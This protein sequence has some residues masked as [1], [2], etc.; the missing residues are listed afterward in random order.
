[1]KRAGFTLIE[2][3]VAMIVTGI[4]TGMVF[5][6][7]AGEQG[8]YTR[9]REK[10][11]MQ[12]DAR[13]AM[14]IIEE[15]VRNAGYA[16]MM[17]ATSRIETTPSRCAEVVFPSSGGSILPGN[18]STSL[19]TGDTIVFRFY[20]IPPSGSLAACGTG[21]SSRFREI[22]Y[23]LDNGT[24]KRRYR[25]DTT[26]AAD[27]IPFLENVVSFQVRYG[28]V[29]DVGNLVFD[30]T[31]LRTAS[32][33]DPV[34][35]SA[36]MLA[37]GGSSSTLA[38]SG[39]GLSSRYAYFGPIDTSRANESYR[40]SMYLSANDSLLD[41]TWGYDS[42]SLSIGLVKSNLASYVGICNF[43]LGQ[44]AGVA[45]PYEFYFT[46]GSANIGNVYLAL[47]G[48]LRISA[49]AGAQTLTVS[50]L[51]VER[52]SRGSYFTW[53]DSPSKAEMAKVAAVRINLVVKTPLK[54]GEGSPQGFSTDQLGDLSLP[55]GYTAS[56]ADAMKSH[57]LYQRIIPVVNNRL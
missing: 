52:I 53:I 20:E 46:A 5:R 26:T 44:V 22:G 10:V 41:A 12:A 18:N 57:I 34:A 28:L 4:V 31:R 50:R 40:L 38:F 24:L 43:K 30:T 36:G 25:T 48:R 6:M 9:T 21:S 8:N 1:V 23:R 47:S 15:E 45:V 11:K 3:L 56:G 16:T 55:S 54:S 2:L 32:Y 27:W 19:A 49:T 35:N 29:E 17:S 33:W 39:F 7:F 42:T 13:E 37:V 51:K 14:R